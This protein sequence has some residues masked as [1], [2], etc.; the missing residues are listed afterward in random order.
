MSVGNIQISV[1]APAAVA[2]AP[3]AAAVSQQVQVAAPAKSAAP[4]KTTNTAKPVTPVADSSSSSDAA[5]LSATAVVLSGL[6]F[7]LTTSKPSDFKSLLEGAARSIYTAAQQQ[8]SREQTR[9]LE[10]IANRLQVV[11]NIAGLS[12]H[13]PLSIAAILE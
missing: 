4:A 2:E 12:S 9:T 13:S 10:D 6:E 1:V 3:A 11:A 7:Q 5:S 8:E